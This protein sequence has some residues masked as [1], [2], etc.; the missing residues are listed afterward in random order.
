MTPNPAAPPAGAPPG[1]SPA[2]DALN[3]PSILILICGALGVV[4]ALVSMVSRNPQQFDQMFAQNPDLARQM[5]PFLK[6]MTGPVSIISNLLG[7]AIS[8]FMIFGALKM[9][10]LQSYGVAMAAAIVS[11]L[12][13]TSCCCVSL[14]VG[15]WALV[16]LMKPEVKASF[17]G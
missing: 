15:I 3:V 6:M 5:G 1:T 10:N 17:T 16:V 7:A 13:C 12:P 14:P 11:L 4:L 2:Q 9:R 8:G